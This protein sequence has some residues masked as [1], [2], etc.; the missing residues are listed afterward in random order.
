MKLTACRSDLGQGGCLTDAIFIFRQLHCCRK[1]PGKEGGPVL[2]MTFVDSEKA[3]EIVPE[4]V[5]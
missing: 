1:I 3:F 5:V 4:E 2:W